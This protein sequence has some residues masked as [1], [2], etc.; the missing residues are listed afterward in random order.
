MSM[1]KEQ[2]IMFEGVM[3]VTQADQCLVTLYKVRKIYT[4]MLAPDV[5][6]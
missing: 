2:H 4:S 3:H 6:I 1:H 5:F